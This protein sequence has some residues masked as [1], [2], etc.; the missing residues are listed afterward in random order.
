MKAF[1]C[2]VVM[3][4][5]L[6]VFDA[7]WIGLF[8]AGLYQS[9]IPGMLKEE[10]NLVAAL[11]FYVGYPLGAYWLAVRPAVGEGSLQSALINGAVLGAVA[12]GTFAVT[13][14]AVLNN[15]TVTLTVVDTIWGACVTG[16][17]A[18]IGYLVAGRAS[19]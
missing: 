17:T 19:T 8:M 16:A 6:L 9:E 4:F 3:L 10:A 2:I 7:I 12:Y 15:W 1:K 13:N 18:A 5:A 14:L 11:V